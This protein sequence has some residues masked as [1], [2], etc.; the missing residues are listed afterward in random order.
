MGGIAP[1]SPFPSAPGSV[2]YNIV[3]GLPQSVPAPGGQELFL[4]RVLVSNSKTA[5]AGSC[6]G[7]LSGSCLG[8]S[9]IW[10]GQPNTGNVV[11]VGEIP[12]THSNT[13]GW[14]MSGGAMS[15]VLAHSNSYGYYTDFTAC[16]SATDAQ[17]PTWGQI[18][19]LYR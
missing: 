5:G 11:R 10:L 13:V 6:T 2:N 7:C 16:S 12:G 19:K 8:I 15:G 17:R 3:C 4:A 14:Q 1:A 9:K 18:K